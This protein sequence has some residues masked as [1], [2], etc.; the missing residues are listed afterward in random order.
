MEILFFS[1]EHCTLCRKLEGALHNTN[2]LTRVK[3]IVI[4]PD[5]MELAKKYNINTLPVLLKLDD[6]WNEV[7]RLCGLPPLSK[8]REFIEA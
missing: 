2:L 8:V 3:H 5:D 7:D 1:S 4:N 6:D